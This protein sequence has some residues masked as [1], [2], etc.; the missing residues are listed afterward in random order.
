[1]ANSNSSKKSLNKKEFNINPKKHQNFTA[2]D[3]QN[4]PN[5]KKPPIDLDDTEKNSNESNTYSDNLFKLYETI[6]ENSSRLSEIINMINENNE[7]N[8]YK[9]EAIKRMQKRLEEHERGLIKSIKE[10]LVKDILRF[11]DSLNAFINK[12]SESTYTKEEFNKELNILK[13][14]FY[15]LLFAQNIELINSNVNQKYD[16]NIQKVIRTESTYNL[17]EDCIVSNVIRDGF[18]WNGKILRKQEIIIK[19]Y[20][21]KIQNENSME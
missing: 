15:E 9:D 10:S 17:D 21:N 8:K 12:F 11:Y 3:S 20:N 16:R 4:K 5:I 7:R 6:S 13:D 19:K 18:I 1:M 2:S 14:E